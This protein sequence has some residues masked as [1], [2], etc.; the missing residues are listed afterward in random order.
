MVLNLLNGNRITPD[1][2]LHEFGHALGFLHEMHHG[3]WKGCADAFDVV[4]YAQDVNFGPDVTPE[5]AVKKV[6]KNIKKLPGQYRRAATP[7]TYVFER[8]GIMSYQIEEKYFDAGRVDP[9]KCAMPIDAIKL[10]PTDIAL[11]LGI[12]GD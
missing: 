1:K 8:F 9:K 7:Q 2:V 6:V 12:Y 5:E 4:A 11:F 3:K 10:Q